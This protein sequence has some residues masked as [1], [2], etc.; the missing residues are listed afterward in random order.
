MKRR[1]EGVARKRVS[2]RGEGGTGESA[3]YRLY[4]GSTRRA[5]ANARVEQGRANA[6]YLDTLVGEKEETA[7]ASRSRLQRKWWKGR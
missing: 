6:T 5:S 7:T 1:W 4:R 3:E 2:R